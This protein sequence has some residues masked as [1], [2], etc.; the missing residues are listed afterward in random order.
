MVGQHFSGT[1]TA[2]VLK[3]PPRCRTIKRGEMSAQMAVRPCTKVGWSHD[4]APHEACSLR[5]ATSLCVPSEAKMSNC[6]RETRSVSALCDGF[7]CNTVLQVMRS[8]ESTSSLKRVSAGINSG[9]ME[10]ASSAC[11]SLSLGSDARD[12]AM[13]AA[14]STCWISVS[15]RPPYLR[16]PRAERAHAGSSVP[17]IS[18]RPFQITSKMTYYNRSA[19]ESAM[20][21]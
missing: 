14:F 8:F 15:P 18:K 20:E 2:S 13:K 6:R 21:E 7:C 1:A 17:F 4:D 5:R 3:L 12:A 9:S 10:A 11:A 19:H 16:S